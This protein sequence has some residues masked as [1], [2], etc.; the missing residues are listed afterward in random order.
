MAQDRPRDPS[1]HSTQR[2]P[3]AVD[4]SSP[5]GWP[6]SAVGQHVAEYLGLIGHQPVD[7]EI[8]ET[9]HLVR[10]VDGPDVD[11]DAPLMEMGDQPWGDDRDAA[12]GHR[13]LGCL[14]RRNGQPEAPAA[15]QQSESATGPRADR[16]LGPHERPNTVDSAIAERSDHDPIGRIGSQNRVRERLDRRVVFG[17]EVD[18]GRRKDLEE[19]V[20]SHDRFGSRDAGLAHLRPGEFGNE[21]RGVGHPIQTVV[22]EGDRNA[23][24][25]HVHVG[26]DVGEP[27]LECVAKCPFGVLG[28][29]A[30]PSAMSEGDR[31]TDIE[32]G[33][34]ARHAVTV[35]RYG[36][37]VDAANRLTDLLSDDRAVPLDEA[38]LLLAASRPDTRCSLPDGIAAL[39]ALASSCP[40]DSLESLIRHVFVDQGF[41]GDRADYHD[42]RNSY[43]DQVLDR[44]VGMPITLAVVLV[45]VGRRLGIALDGVGMPGHFLVREREQPDAFIDPFHQGVRIGPDACE[46]RFRT[47]HGPTAEFHPSYL[48][49][50]ASRSIVQ[51]VLNNLT[52]TFRS[53]DP[54]ALDWLLDIRI[55]IPADPPDLRALA[56]L[57]ELRG[58]YDDAADLLDRVR[59]VAPAGDGDR[60][61]HDR[62]HRLR[63]RLN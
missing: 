41:S 21:A 40:D 50:V 42:P 5:P 36:R 1:G 33:V 54:R 32:I 39:D 47:I 15:S 26:L 22:V 3:R 14:H 38:L 57:C 23:V 29:N 7:A 12:Y 16:Q 45:E 24:E 56:D 17:V 51:R 48:L 25:G 55:R 35:V 8:E 2:R 63:S 53:R 43:L 37:S 30:G 4:R 60:R 10:V 52:V 46:A 58:R 6:G 27:E 49:P 19:L 18:A 62:A 28:V 13:H 34:D 20:E 9:V 31:M 11:L 59:D 61:I 44:R